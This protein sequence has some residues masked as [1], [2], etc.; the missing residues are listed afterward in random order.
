MINKEY[1]IGGNMSNENQNAL[2]KK[3]GGVQISAETLTGEQKEA[4]QKI[5]NIVD[6]NPILDWR[7]PNHNTD[8][9]IIEKKIEPVKNF[10]LKAQ[11]LAGLSVCNDG[12]QIHGEGADA[13]IVSMV[14][15]WREGENRRVTMAGASTV[16]ECGGK[17]YQKNPKINPRA[18]HDAVARSQTRAMKNAIEAYMGF[19]FVNIIL[20]ML[21]G[22]YEINDPDG[23]MKDGGVNP[24]SE[25]VIQRKR[26]VNAAWKKVKDSVDRGYFT[27][28]EKDRYRQLLENSKEDIT[29]LLKIK[30]EI[31]KLAEERRGEKNK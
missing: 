14:S 10:H 16:A 2:M 20:Q 21:F 29:E 11:F 18:F 27:E 19:P 8:F 3:T 15:V 6:R 26:V 13:M 23:A 17:G 4:F 30:T 9:C 1:C 24:E 25:D 31:D 22:G 28:D 5:I 12:Y 7:N